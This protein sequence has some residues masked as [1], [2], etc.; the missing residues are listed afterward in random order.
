MPTP[1]NIKTNQAYDLLNVTINDIIESRRATMEDK[2][3]LLSMLL[4]SQDENGEQMS[5]RQIRDEAMVY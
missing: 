3:D 5:D 1:R 2:G 4:L